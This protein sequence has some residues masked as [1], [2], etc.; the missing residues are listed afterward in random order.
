MAQVSANKQVA[1][2]QVNGALKQQQPVQQVQKQ[3]VANS[4]TQFVNSPKQVVV[5]NNPAQQ[6]Q[7]IMQR[8]P[9]QVKK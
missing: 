3:V 4:N 9:L 7:Q 6:L 8:P 1:P 2:Q 5:A